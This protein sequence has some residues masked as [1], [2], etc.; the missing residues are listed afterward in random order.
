MSEVLVLA[1]EA[2]MLVPAPGEVALSLVPAPADVSLV[3]AV[4]CPAAGGWPDWLGGLMYG[5]KLPPESEIAMSQMSGLRRC[6]A[7]LAFTV[8]VCWS[9]Q[10]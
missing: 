6:Q 2:N 8:A 4:C 1:H 10:S 3:T 7:R 5:S 9:R